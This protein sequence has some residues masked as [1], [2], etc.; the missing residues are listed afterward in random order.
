M[1]VSINELGPR[2]SREGTPDLIVKITYNRRTVIISRQLERSGKLNL[3][4]YRMYQET[5]MN[6]MSETKH[7][8]NRPQ[9][10]GQP[11]SNALT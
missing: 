3:L 5:E 9:K 7:S 8:I 6:L 4:C 10:P 11:S 1:G 2:Y